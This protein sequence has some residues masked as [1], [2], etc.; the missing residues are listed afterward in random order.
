MLPECKPVV[1]LVVLTGLPWDIVRAAAT[2]IFLWL[3]AN[4]M[5]EK[6]TRIQQKYGL[7]EP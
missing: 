6:L 2:V 4:P 7:L 5:L 1:A 3:M